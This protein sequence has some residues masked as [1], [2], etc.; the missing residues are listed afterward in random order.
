[1]NKPPRFDAL[2]NLLYTEHE[3]IP[4]NLVTLREDS[5]A[6]PAE[7]YTPED[8]AKMD[9]R[10][11]RY[12][13]LRNRARVG[14]TTRPVRPTPKI[15]P[16]AVIPQNEPSIQT[17]IDEPEVDE[18]EQDL[19]DIRPNVEPVID[20]P[21]ETPRSNGVYSQAIIDYVKN[22]PGTTRKDLFTYLS[23]AF[24]DRLNTEDQINR[25]IRH[26]IQQGDIEFNDED[27]VSIPGDASEIEPPEEELKKMDAP[28]GAEARSK[29]TKDLYRKFMAWRQKKASGGEEESE[30]GGEE[31]ED[32]PT[33]PADVAM[34]RRR[35]VKPSR[36]T[37]DDTDAE[38]LADND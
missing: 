8:W 24:G 7:G 18:P 22:A 4:E 13:I 32:E 26:A 17:S 15:N 28:K 36:N 25:V 38:A 30:D 37:D 16:A 3:V 14:D 5:F 27:V 20:E 10:K 1:M 29:E 6:E 12:I 35:Y 23:G 21:I 31:S 19:A 33:V 2:A 9:Y 11:R 34:Q